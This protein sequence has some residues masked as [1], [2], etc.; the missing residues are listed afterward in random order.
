MT[1][2]IHFLNQPE[3]PGKNT[4][5]AHAFNSEIFIHNISIFICFQLKIEPTNKELPGLMGYFSSAHNL[6]AIK[7]WVIKAM[8]E[9]M[10][11]NEFSEYRVLSAFIDFLQSRGVSL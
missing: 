7:D 6:G 10:I 8:P 2:N 11:A 5:E 3:L 9:I 1:Q 4:K